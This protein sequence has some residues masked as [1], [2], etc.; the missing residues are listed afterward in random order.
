L[1]LPEVR[2]FGALSR[3]SI[4]AGIRALPYVNSLSAF[5]ITHMKLSRFEV[6]TGKFSLQVGTQAFINT[7]LHDDAMGFFRRK[8]LFSQLFVAYR[9]DNSRPIEITF[10]GSYHGIIGLNGTVS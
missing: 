8:K 7:F 10:L 1:V 4:A 5:I 3:T 6:K 2:S 9:H